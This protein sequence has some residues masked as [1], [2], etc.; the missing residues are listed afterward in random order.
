MGVVSK[1]RRFEL[2]EELIVAGVGVQMMP[3]TSAKNFVGIG[4]V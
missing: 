3:A 2:C 1:H 4:R